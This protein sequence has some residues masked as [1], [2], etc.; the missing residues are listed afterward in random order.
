MYKRYRVERGA[1][2]DVLAINFRHFQDKFPPT[3]EITT[4][5]FLHSQSLRL[6]KIYFH[7]KHLK[8]ID[9]SLW[10]FSTKLVHFLFFIKHIETLW[11]GIALHPL[12]QEKKLKSWYEKK[13]WAFLIFDEKANNSFTSYRSNWLLWGQEVVGGAIWQFSIVGKNLLEL[14]GCSANTAG[15]S[16]IFPK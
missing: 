14:F 3:F 5:A 6:W 7:N 16:K 9:T 15:T 1:D 11:T 8:W 10:N 12:L 4:T 2:S 13:N